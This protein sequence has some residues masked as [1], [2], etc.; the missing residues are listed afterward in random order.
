MNEQPYVIDLPTPPSVNAMFANVPRVGR[1]KTAAYKR[2]ITDAGWFVNA[3]G[4]FHT[5]TVAVRC[6]IEIT[7][8]NKRRRDL[9]NCA[10]PVLDLLVKMGVI[11]DDSLV[12]EIIMRWRYGDTGGNSAGTTVTVSE[13]GTAP[14]MG[15]AA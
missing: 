8:T 9:D 5:L 3:A 7:R 11:A 15:G 12:D 10:K 2:W 4:P 1:V 6:V 14:A 13:M